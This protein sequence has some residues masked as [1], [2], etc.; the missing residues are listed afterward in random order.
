MSK[1][2]RSIFICLILLAVCLTAHAAGT[3]PSLPQISAPL[4]VSPVATFRKLLTMT[5]EEQEKALASR[6]PQ[7]R[8]IIAAK[9]FEYEAMPPEAR[10]LRLRCTELHWYLVKLMR[11]AP[12]ER[13][14]ALEQVPPLERPQIKERLQLWDQ[15][16]AE[17][18]KK[19]LDNESE[20]TM[21]GLINL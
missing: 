16:P 18:Q 19:F 20:W 3:P 6:T 5:L 2:K 4:P 14:A 11:M 7:Q 13:A 21:M 9:L 10:I 8:K 1:L 15:L 12:E 17:L